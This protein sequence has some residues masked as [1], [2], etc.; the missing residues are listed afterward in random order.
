M[1]RVIALF[2]ACIALLVGCSQKSEV[3]A[4][5]P[6][7]AACEEVL[8]SYES[9]R[10]RRGIEVKFRAVH[11]SVRPNAHPGLSGYLEIL[12]DLSDEQLLEVRNGLKLVCMPENYIKSEITELALVTL[13][14]TL[15]EHRGVG[16]QYIVLDSGGLSIYQNSVPDHMKKALLH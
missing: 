4:V 7:Y 14:S 2:S 9:S 12:G 16:E 6:L 3:L 13:P 10:N 11:F 8:S 1:F 5:L 15:R